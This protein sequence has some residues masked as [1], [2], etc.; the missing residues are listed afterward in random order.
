MHVKQ[1]VL[2]NQFSGGPSLRG[3]PGVRAQ[4]GRRSERQCLASCETQNA[5][6]SI[7]FS[8]PIFWWPTPSWVLWSDWQVNQCVFSNQS[9]GD[10]PL[11]GAPGVRAQYGKRIEGQ[12]IALW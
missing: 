5:S 4:Y 1:L 6:E 8:Q 11:R 7:V 3:S 2:L 9:S 10:Q 12:C